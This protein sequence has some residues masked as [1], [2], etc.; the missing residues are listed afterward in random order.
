VSLVDAV[1][2]VDQVFN[3]VLVGDIRVLLGDRLL[4]QSDEVDQAPA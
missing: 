2:H 3:D 4:S 1:V